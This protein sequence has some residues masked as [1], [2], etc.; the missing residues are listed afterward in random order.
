VSGGTYDDLIWVKTIDRNGNESSA[1]IGRN[2]N[3]GH[4]TQR[5]SPF[6]I[7]FGARLTF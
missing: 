5:Y 4:T 1:P 3:F 6:Y 2:P 7:R